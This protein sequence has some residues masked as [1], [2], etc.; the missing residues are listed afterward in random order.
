MFPP[1]ENTQDMNALVAQLVQ[2]E[3]QRQQQQQQ[4]PPGQTPTAPVVSNAP[5]PITVPI[6]GQTFTFQTPEEIGRA[7][8]Q[9]ADQASRAV[10]EAQAK[11]AQPQP[12]QVVKGDE[13]LPAF[14]F[15]QFAEQLTTDKAPDAIEMAIKAKTGISL[16]DLKAMKEKLETQENE[17]AEQRRVMAAATFRDNHPEYLGHNQNAAVLGNILQQNGWDITPENLEAAY[18]LAVTRN[19]VQIDPSQLP[20]FQQQQQFQQVPQ[21]DFGYPPQLQ[22]Q[23][24]AAPFAQQ[25]MPMPDPR[26]FNGGFGVSNAPFAPGVQGPPRV[27]RAGWQAPQGLMQM[28]ESLSVDQLEAILNQASVPLS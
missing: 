2:Q 23:Q 24:P 18:A 19:L 8:A 3:F 11:G 10:A 6:N 13:Q 20:Q 14:N 1:N 25:S 5:A 4:T 22:P 15:A 21:Q 28:A 16:E 7:F 12:G 9:F 17:L 27:P 26:A